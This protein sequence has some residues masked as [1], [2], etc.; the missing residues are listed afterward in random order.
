MD[1]INQKPY[2]IHKNPLFCKLFT[3]HLPFYVKILY[4]LSIPKAHKIQQPA[5][6]L[7]SDLNGKKIT[8]PKRKAKNK[9]SAEPFLQNRKFKTCEAGG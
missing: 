1:N 7:S 9:N 2:N 6:R 4:I 3:R 5:D 8:F